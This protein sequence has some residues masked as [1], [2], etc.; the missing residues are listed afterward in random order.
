[1]GNKDL[2]LENPIIIL[3]EWIPFGKNYITDFIDRITLKRYQKTKKYF[4][5]TDRI[6]EPIFKIE[7]FYSKVE[8]LQFIPDVSIQFRANYE[9]VDM[10][11]YT[12]YL[13]RVIYSSEIPEKL[14]VRKL[15]FI[16]PDLILKSS[17][18]IINFISPSQ[19]FILEGL[20][21]EIK[22]YKHISILV[23]NTFELSSENLSV[24]SQ[25]IGTIKNIIRVDDGF[26]IFGD[27]GLLI[28]HKEPEKF[29]KFIYYY[30]FIRS[31][32]GVLKDV[33]LKIN[34]IASRLENIGEMLEE[35]VDWDNVGKI[36]GELSEIDR[37][38]AIIE[39]TLGYLDE[40]IEILLKNYPPN[41]DEFEL[42]LLE[43][44]EA[45]RKIERLSY[46]L[47]EIKNILK[48]NENLATSLARLLTTISEDLEREIVSQLAL[49]TK[50]QV[51]LGEAMELLEI[52]IFG[53]YALEAVHILLITSG[54]ED[55][56]HH[57][58]FLNFPL[59]FWIVLFSTVFGILVGTYLIKRK[60]RKILHG[61]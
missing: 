45:K 10:V 16:I 52:G 9:N 20:H 41:F 61:C 53:V 28:A 27:Y 6:D 56:V 14:S 50:Y 59:D 29:E 38:M 26:I 23:R 39:T 8:V 30:P 12:D 44:L 3:N 43:L 25:V 36:R 47:I 48:S 32:T 18:L 22:I 4:T 33:F 34:D 15:S 1:M 19:R 37:E 55:K 7:K 11:I 57:F 49:N 60:K 51:A 35:S 2:M 5:A 13:G 42:N 54:Y 58:Y 24:V 31:L 46:R 21:G 17:K 40:V